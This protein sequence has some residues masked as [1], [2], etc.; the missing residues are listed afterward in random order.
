MRRFPLAL[1]SAR[2]RALS[3][4]KMMRA[5]VLCPL[6]G[7]GRGEEKGAFDDFGANYQSEAAKAE[8]IVPT[9]AMRETAHTNENEVKAIAHRARP[10]A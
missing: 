7:S 2:G 8:A 4:M 9:K 1:S 3:G 5:L 6:A 10:S